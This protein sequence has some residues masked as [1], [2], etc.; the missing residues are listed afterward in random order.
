MHRRS[1]GA[2]SALEKA[3]GLTGERSRKMVMTKTQ[4]GRPCIIFYDPEIEDQHGTTKL[5]PSIIA[6]RDVLYRRLTFD[7][8]AIKAARRRRR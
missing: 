7:R 6:A 3:K 4:D 2:M 1:S 8:R 5:S